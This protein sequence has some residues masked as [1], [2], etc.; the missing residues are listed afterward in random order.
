MSLASTLMTTLGPEQL[1]ADQ[2]ELSLRVRSVVVLCVTIALIAVPTALLQVIL[3]QLFFL[4]LDLGALATAI[5]SLLVLRWTRSPGVAAALIGAASCAM[6]AAAMSTDGGLQSP[7]VVYLLVVPP[8]LYALGGPTFGIVG[9]FAISAGLAVLWVGGDAFAPWIAEGDPVRNGWY[10]VQN[11]VTTALVVLALLWLRERSWRQAISDA[12]IQER[13]RVAAEAESRSK[14]VVLASM[15]HEIRTP[16]N[17]VLGTVEILRGRNLAESDRAEIEVIAESGQVLLT[18]LNDILD[19]AKADAGLLEVT[20]EPVDTEHLA[21]TVI[22]LHAG[23]AQAKGLVLRQETST[24]LPRALLGDAQR[25]RQ[26]L[27]NLVGNAVKF[28][29]AGEIVV[30]QQVRDGRWELCV[31][32]T[33][34]G[35]P[36]DRQE[37]IFEPFV[38]AE[39][40]TTRRY[41][42]TGL[43]LS[44]SRRLVELMGGT[45]TVTSQAGSGSTFTVSLPAHPASLPD[46][47]ES[48]TFA[49]RGEDL[50]VLVA[51]DNQVNQHVIRALLEREGHLVYMVGDGAEAVE[52]CAGTSFDLVLMDI[53]MPVMDGLEATRQIR[54]THGS[55]LPI[56]GLS[57]SAFADE[58][59]RALDAGMNAYL[60]KPVDLRELRRALATAH[61]GRQSVPDRAQT[62]TLRTG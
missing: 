27:L 33:G 34:I 51:E 2:P 46:V 40:G 13:A 57:A 16:L 44:I 60:S 58:I 6:L 7:G 42:G 24:D 47:V 10:I 55:D 29:E 5:L 23:S 4:V 37:A 35:I 9:T 52:A 11:Y 41:G 18:I 26:V 48:P 53:Q 39:S 28:T 15:S 17:G 54:R 45:L 3:G 30:R 31:R 12:G 62:G 61:T 25:L 1:P 32:D 21:E 59:Q 14:S 56:I 50:R 36:A 20:E 19:S 8:I 22:R 43:G 38:Q 49:P